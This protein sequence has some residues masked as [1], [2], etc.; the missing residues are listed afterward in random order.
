MLREFRLSPKGSGRGISCDESGAFIGAIPLLEKSVVHGK[1]RWRPRNSDEL[2]KQLGSHFGLPVDIS[3][4][5]GRLKAIANALSD[6]DLA[7]AQIATVLL[8]IPDPPALSKSTHAPDAMIKFICDLH[9]SGL[10]ALVGDRASMELRSGVTPASSTLHRTEGTLTKAGYNPNEPRGYHARWTHGSGS[11]APAAGQVS[12]PAQRNS[13]TP[14]SRANAVNNEPEGSSQSLGSRLR[15]EA[16]TVLTEIGQ[17]QVAENNANLAVSNDET[18]AVTGWLRDL[19]NYSAKTWIGADGRPVRISIINTGD[20]NSD[21]GALIAHA[22]L[23]PNAPLTRPGTNADWIGALIALGSAGAMAS[24][25]SLRPADAEPT[26][27]P[28]PTAPAV[29]RPF[30]NL[31]SKLP[32]DF[33]ASQPIGRFEPRDD[34]SHVDFGN[35]AHNEIGNLL[36]KAV[37][38]NIQLELNT[39]PY[40]RG[41]DITVPQRFINDVGFEYG[42]IKPLS[43]TGRSRFNNQVLNIW[44]LE[45]RVQPITYDRNGN[46]YYGFPGYDEP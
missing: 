39:A 8:G 22:I 41:V 42:E 31:R 13:D 46:I 34:L 6:G 35:Y 27:V 16:E 5:A 28:E 11:A 38:T 3:P 14:R 10:L 19:A 24:R 18:H 44:N 32:A 25:P 45:E 1:D 7:R 36:Q 20:P 29:N 26:V 43:R 15:N 33:D 4:K 2:S 9:W 30:I 40:A 12:K 23:E 21:Q 37:G 17:A